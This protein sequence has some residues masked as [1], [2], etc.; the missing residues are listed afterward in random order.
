[1]FAFSGRLFGIHAGNIKEI[2]KS[3]QKKLYV[4]EKCRTDLQHTSDPTLDSAI[5][6][7]KHTI[8]Q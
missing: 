5:P 4:F 8:N 6:A 2:L 1:M 3:C 7:T